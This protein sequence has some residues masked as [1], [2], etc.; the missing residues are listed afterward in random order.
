MLW[1]CVMT[2]VASVGYGGGLRT[3]NDEVKD[4]GGDHVCVRIFSVG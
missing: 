2:W 4:D 1:K 3:T